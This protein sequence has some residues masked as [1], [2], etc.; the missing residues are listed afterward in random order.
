MV[1]YLQRLSLAA[2]FA[3][4]AVAP[5]LPIVAIPGFA[6]RPKSAPKGWTKSRRTVAQDRRAAAK[7][8]ARI[9]AKKHGQA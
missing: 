7:R 5:T 3:D 6:G 4:M 2:L 1:S 8:R 9:R